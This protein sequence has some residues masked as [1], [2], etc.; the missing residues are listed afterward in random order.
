MKKQIKSLVVKS[1]RFHHQDIHS[2][3][4]QMKLTIARLEGKIDALISLQN[5]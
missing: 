5:K 2:E 3:I 1:L 4:E